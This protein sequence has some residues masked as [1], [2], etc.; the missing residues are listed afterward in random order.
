M[1]NELNIPERYNE[2]GKLKVYDENL[3]KFKLER[4]PIGN[5][6]LSRREDK[7]VTYEAE[8]IETTVSSILLGY[9][10]NKLQLS[11]GSYVSLEEFIRAT[12]KALNSMGENTV[13]VS[14]KTGKVVEP[15]KLINLLRAAVKTS[16]K[17]NIGSTNERFIERTIVG[18]NGS[19]KKSSPI[20]AKEGFKI[21]TGEYVSLE[22]LQTALNNYV[23]ATPEVTSEIS[24]QKEE[25]NIVVRISEKYSLNMKRIL[26]CS[27]TSIIILLTGLGIST[28]MI[29]KIVDNNQNQIVEVVEYNANYLIKVNGIEYKVDDA[30]FNQYLSKYTLDGNINLPN[31]LEFSEYGNG[32]GA[33]KDFNKFNLEGKQSGDY[34]ISGFAIYNKNGN[35]ISY[36]E[37]FNGKGFE[38]TNLS[39]KTDNLMNF[40]EQTLKENPNLSEDDIDIKLHFGDDIKGNRLGWISL[41]EFEQAIEKEK[42]NVSTESKE[43]KGVVN[44][45]KGDYITINTEDGPV[46]IKIVD[47]N[48]NYLTPGRTVL[49]S[50]NKEYVV[51]YLNIEEN[52]NQVE[53]QISTESNN[54]NKGVVVTFNILP[55]IMAASVLAGLT[56]IEAAK[57][58]KLNEESKKKIRFKEFEN[59]EEYKQFLEEFQNRK[60]K[61]EGKSKF[62]KFF[63]NKREF[64]QK[65]TREQI[66]EIYDIIRL[67]YGNDVTIKIA[68]DRFQVVYPDGSIIDV[69]ESSLK[70]IR[71]IGKD[72][73]Y[74]A[75]TR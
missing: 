29:Q 37:M 16:S 9:N 62:A 49:G 55:G 33:K 6:D 12:Q 11:D 35:L 15:S 61:Y 63:I 27:L 21:G 45:F 3:P 14:T 20:I 30:N 38:N 18:E 4:H 51:G 57:I 59:T 72:N 65:Y 24:Q 28:N 25:K 17:I 7:S 19:K 60:V 68:N 23:L 26:L 13:V 43:Y 47:E 1:N 73:A 44:D 36:I 64:V 2:S 54:L 67:K 70:D 5:G 48:G 8:G 42:S 66:I 69:E 22:E 75:H 34:N 56:A 32:T 10:K 58:K 74:E 41:D 46:S 31:D 40:I 39:I 50:D 52:V 53:N 71:E